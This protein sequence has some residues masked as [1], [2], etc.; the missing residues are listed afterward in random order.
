MGSIKLEDILR[1]PVITEKG[2]L[3]QQYQNAH[4]FEVDRAANKL[5]IKQAVEKLFEVKVLNVRTM[6]MPR[7][8]KRVGRQVGQTQPWKKAVIT[9]AEGQTLEA[10]EP[11]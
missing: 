2:A 9:L 1:R 8:W 4:V 3:M 11:K 7:K 10:I 6:V 5:Q